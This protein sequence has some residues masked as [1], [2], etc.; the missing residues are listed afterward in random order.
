MFTLIWCAL[1][2][3]LEIDLTRS[4]VFFGK[5]GNV[6]LH[7]SFFVFKLRSDL[8]NLSRVQHTRGAKIY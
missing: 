8:S 5:E 6:R 1:I 4:T 7:S 3:L 2:L